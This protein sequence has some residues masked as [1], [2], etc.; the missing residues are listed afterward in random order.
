LKEGD[1]YKELF[2]MSD[3]I[4]L[5]FIRTFNDKNPLHTNQN[6][7]IEKGFKD[8]VMHGNILGG[9]LSYFIGECLPIQEVA[10]LEQRMKFHNPFYI[11]DS[12]AL[13]AKITQISEAVGF[14]KF[15][16]E[17]RNQASLLIAKGEIQIKKI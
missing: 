6:F 12:L 5:D 7:A 4:Y 8:I 3:K 9:F 11:G 14:I 13:K 17:F 16:C 1:I 15:K 2:V 10:I